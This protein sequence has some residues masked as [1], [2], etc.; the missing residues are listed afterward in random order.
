MFKAEEFA[1]WY[2][3]LNGFLTIP[4]FVL[5]PNRPGPQR[6]DADIIGIRFPFRKEFP[7]GDVD[8]SLLK[9]SASK[10]SLYFAEVK[11]RQMDLNEAW[12]NRDKKNINRAL[13]AIGLLKSEKSVRETAD[14]LYSK[15]TYDGKSYYCSLLFI[16]NVDEGRIPSRYDLVPRI[17]WSHIINFVHCRFREF[18]RIKSDSQQWDDVGKELYRLAECHSELGDYEAKVRCVFGLPVAA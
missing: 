5:H 2:L 9:L 16:G 4:N 14:A 17:L 10:P 7:G 13:L 6:T 15:G 18:L 11:S 1:S 3:R 8:D 12:Q